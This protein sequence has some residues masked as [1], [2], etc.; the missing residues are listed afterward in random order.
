MQATPWK[1]HALFNTL[2]RNGTRLDK[3]PVVGGKTGDFIGAVRPVS[4]ANPGRVWP[5]VGLGRKRDGSK[6]AFAARG[7]ACATT[8]AQVNINQGRSVATFVTGTGLIRCGKRCTCQRQPGCTS[9]GFKKR[10]AL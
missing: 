5:G 2:D 10:P 3:K 9:H 8:V 6:V 1:K 7:N 4:G